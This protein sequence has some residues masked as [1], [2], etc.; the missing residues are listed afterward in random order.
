MYTAGKVVGHAGDAQA[1]VGG[2]DR[3]VLEE[4]CQIAGWVLRRRHYILGTFAQP[5][6]ALLTILQGRSFT[7]PKP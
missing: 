5:I 2:R 6:Q 3:A 4:A 1:V 7:P